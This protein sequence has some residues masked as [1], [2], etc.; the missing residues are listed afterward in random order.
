METYEIIK[1]LLTILAIGISA[2]AIGISAW[3]IILQLK[4]NRDLETIKYLFAVRKEIWEL[5]EKSKSFIESKKQIGQK[6]EYLATA[7][8]ADVL[9]INLLKKSCGKWFQSK[10]R[11]LEIVKDDKKKKSD[12]ESYKEIITLYKKLNDIYNE[13]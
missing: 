10:V 8:N 13:N 11:K 6:L 4:K 5:D 3:L 7:V 9:D 1:I 12:N 2:L